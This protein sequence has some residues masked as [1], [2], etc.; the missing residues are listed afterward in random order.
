LLEL[1]ITVT[2][3]DLDERL[4]ELEEEVHR[5]DAMQTGTLRLA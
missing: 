4:T 2:A 3:D 5:R 1:G